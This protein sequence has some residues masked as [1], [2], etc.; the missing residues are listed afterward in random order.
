M[1]EIC[2]DEIGEPGAPMCWGNHR[3]EHPACT[4]C[5]VGSKC[6]Q[7]KAD[8]VERGMR[9]VSRALEEHGKPEA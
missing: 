6:H 9:A 2:I 5:P 4:T 8:L 3:A 1:L 7:R